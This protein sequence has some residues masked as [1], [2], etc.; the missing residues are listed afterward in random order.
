M[1]PRCRD[2]TGSKP[3]PRLFHHPRALNLF[4]EWAP[5]HG[6]PSLTCNLP[7]ASSQ[8]N[9]RKSPQKKKSDPGAKISFFSWGVLVRPISIHWGRFWF[10]CTLQLG[11]WTAL[12]GVQQKEKVV[13]DFQLPTVAV[14]VRFYLILFSILI[15]FSLAYYFYLCNFSA[16]KAAKSLGCRERGH[17]RLR[18]DGE[19]RSKADFLPRCTWLSGT[20]E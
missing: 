7:Y 3:I 18:G 20:P 13:S 9:Q 11:L 14:P 15:S 2:L 6:S 16:E 4:K 10:G 5:L 12:H 1:D 19:S 8:E 17:S